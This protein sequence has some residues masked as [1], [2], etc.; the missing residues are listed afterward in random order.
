VFRWTGTATQ[1]V[2]TLS[3]LL[4]ATAQVGIN[5]APSTSFAGNASDGLNDS[6]ANA[7]VSASWFPGGQYLSAITSSGKHLI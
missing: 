6:A 7:Y 4:T 5:G 1:S 2:P 3:V